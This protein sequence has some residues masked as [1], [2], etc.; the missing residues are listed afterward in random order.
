MA[1]TGIAGPAGGTR[2]KPVGMVC[3]ASLLT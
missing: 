2:E 1:T 3:F